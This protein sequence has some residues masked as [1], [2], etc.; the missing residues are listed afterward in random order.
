MKSFAQDHGHEVGDKWGDQINGFRISLE[1]ILGNRQSSFKTGPL[2]DVDS[3]TG[4]EN[5][6]WAGSDDH[7]ASPRGHG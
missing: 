6:N 7:A 4:R 5:E 1:R 3:D 2:S